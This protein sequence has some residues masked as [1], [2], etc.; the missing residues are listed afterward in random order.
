MFWLVHNYLELTVGVGGIITRHDT[1]IV[2]S[3]IYKSN[4]Y[5][6]LRYDERT[7]WWRIDGHEHYCQLTFFFLIIFY[8]L[9]QTQNIYTTLCLREQKTDCKTHL[10]WS[11]EL[12]LLWQKLTSQPYIFF[13]FQLISI[14]LTRNTALAIS[15]W[16]GVD[17]TANE[18]SLNRR[19]TIGT[20]A[21]TQE[22]IIEFLSILHY[23]ES[24]D[25]STDWARRTLQSMDNY[26]AGAESMGQS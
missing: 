26:L 16:W 6:Q 12:F 20:N 15:L 22:K 4:L 8:L 25:I 10:R 24:L 11:V 5:V 19:S 13:F 23:N 18:N 21:C 3:Y 7:L 2:D 1:N 17:T 9:N 14:Y